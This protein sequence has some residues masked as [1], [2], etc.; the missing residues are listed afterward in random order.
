MM[1]SLGVAS[2]LLWKGENI[3]EDINETGLDF[4]KFKVG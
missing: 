3:G 2:K 4:E 1:K